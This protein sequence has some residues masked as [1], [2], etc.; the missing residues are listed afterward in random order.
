MGGD[1]NPSIQPEVNVYSG[2]NLMNPEGVHNNHS[3]QDVGEGA[4]IAIE[5]TAAYNNCM[6][7]Y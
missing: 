1:F 7:L 6:S 3:G 5:K 2:G 4:A